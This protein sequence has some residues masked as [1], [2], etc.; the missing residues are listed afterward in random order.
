MGPL[1]SAPQLPAPQFP[2]PCSKP[3]ISQPPS[4]QPPSSHPP[5]SLSPCSQPPSS[6]SPSSQPLSSKPPSSQ[7][8]PF[9]ALLDPGDHPGA[10][11]DKGQLSTPGWASPMHPIPQGLLPGG[12]TDK[13]SL[14]NKTDK[15]LRKG[16]E[17]TLCKQLGSRACET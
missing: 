16:Q 1:L 5:S 4:S 13:I 14:R 8:P 2:V 3:P 15:T 9:P 11:R 12:Q 7:P 10:V 17:H 6:L